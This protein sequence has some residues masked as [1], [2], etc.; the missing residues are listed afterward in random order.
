MCSA[1]FQLLS[2]NIS[3]REAADHV[4]ILGQ[5]EGPCKAP[6]CPS[7]MEAGPEQTSTK[8]RVRRQ[9][10]YPPSRESSTNLPFTTKSTGTTT[11]AGQGRL[12]STAS[13]GVYHGSQ[14]KMPLSCQDGGP[15]LITAVPGDNTRFE[16]HDP[17]QSK[18][19][20]C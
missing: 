18:Q 9:L 16:Q 3:C 14:T 2:F 11:W 13:P 19:S 4:A 5:A 10:G 7:V 15:L 6:T 8:P 20:Y 1:C 12:A 17:G